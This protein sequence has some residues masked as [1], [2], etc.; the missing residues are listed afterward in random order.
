[1]KNS[2]LPANPLDV[3]Q[4]NFDNAEHRRAFYDA[5]IASGRDK[6]ME[7]RRQ[8]YEHKFIDEQGDPI[9]TFTQPDMVAVGTTRI[10]FF[11]HGESTGNAGAATSDPVTIPLTDVLVE[12][13]PVQEFTYLESGRFAGTTGAER[14]THVDYYWKTRAP[15]YR[16]GPGAE[17]FSDLIR[18]LSRECFQRPSIVTKRECR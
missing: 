2:A 17:R 11:R 14:R 7:H 5:V 6:V 16:D 8:L 10:T 3:D 12:E 1:M 18:S 4:V 9:P 13:W 15:E